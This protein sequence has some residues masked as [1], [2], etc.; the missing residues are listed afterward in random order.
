[1]TGPGPAITL[2]ARDYDAVLFDLDGV[3]TQTASVHA[4]AW[5]ML[6]D[7]FL[8][9]RASLSGEPFV[10][11]DIATDYPRYVDGKP[12]Y[13]GVRSFLESRAIELPLGEPDDGATVQSVRALGK[14]KDQ[15]FQQQLQQQGVEPYAPAIALVHA[16]R[17][18]DI[19]TAVVSSS[20]NCAAVLGAVGIEALFDT[21]VDG[22]DVSRLE[23]KGKPAPDAF[24]EAARRLGIDPARAVVVEDAIAG[25]Q[26]GRAGAFGCVIGVDRRNQAH[27]LRDAGA[28][29][30][31]TDLAQVEVTEDSPSVWSLVFDTFDPAQEGIRE[32]LCTL[33][34]GYFA[35]RGLAAGARADDTHYPGT[36]LAGGYN[37]LRTD[38]AGRT[39]ENEDLVNCPNWLSLEF[40]ID[41]EAW[42]DVRSVK[43]LSYRQELDLRRGM[44]LR[45]IGFEDIQGRRSTLSERRLVSMGD[46]HL[47]AL[48]VALTAD[49]W[50]AAATLRSAVDGRINNAG[51]KLYRK[52]SNQH[53]EAIAAEQVGDDGVC[54]LVRTG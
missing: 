48:E 14:L 39:V 5:K 46:M 35:T 38:I 8:E 3:L 28:D 10:A 34:N 33:G 15:Y 51:A 53:L 20:N 9:Q 4:S 13:D 6:F 7:G 52:F 47:G 41:G 24:L 40:C 25:V 45:R 49:N 29:V 37:R 21:R 26:A 54:L 22:T 44:L 16:L 12:R 1:M 23:L 43:L 2:S 17:A 42:F 30:V 11:F 19:K 50:S 27:A 18:L 32:A 36:Y 31:V